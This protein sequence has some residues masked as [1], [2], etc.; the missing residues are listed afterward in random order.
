MMVERNMVMII[1]DAGVG[2]SVSPPDDE[3]EGVVLVVIFNGSCLTVL[4]AQCI[5]KR[6]NLPDG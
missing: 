3:E 2:P 4:Q 1:S 6:N 5:V